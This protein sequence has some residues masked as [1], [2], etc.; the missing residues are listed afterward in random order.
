LEVD[1]RH[2]LCHHPPRSIGEAPEYGLQT[3]GCKTSV[4][5]EVKP[6]G[7]LGVKANDEFV[8]LLQ[9]L[10]LIPTNKNHNASSNTR[11]STT[12]TMSQQTKD[13]VCEEEED[14]EMKLVEEFEPDLSVRRKGDTRNRSRIDRLLQDSN[15]EH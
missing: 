3:G 5:H 10:E 7:T 13:I 4:Y 14:T 15:G 9:F 11:S 2:Y 1:V 6:L 8:Q 12:D